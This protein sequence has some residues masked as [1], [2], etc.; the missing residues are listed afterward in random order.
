MRSQACEHGIETYPLHKSPTRQRSASH[1]EDSQ[2]KRELEAQMKRKQIDGICIVNRVISP[3]PPDVHD[4]DNTVSKLVSINNSYT[5]VL[6]CKYH[7]EC[8]VVQ[9]QT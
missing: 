7:V 3:I 2:E 4:P 6:S 5:T 1:L 9:N 8:H